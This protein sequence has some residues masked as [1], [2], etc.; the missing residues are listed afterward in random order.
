MGIMF[1]LFIFWFTV[2]FCN[3]CYKIR[4]CLGIAG[5]I[6]NL[7]M[8]SLLILEIF[9]IKRRKII[10]G[11]IIIICIYFIFSIISLIIHILLII[12]K[13]KYFSYKII[14][15]L[16][17]ILLFTD[18]ISS[19][20]N[21]VHFLIVMEEENNNKNVI[22]YV[23][24]IFDIIFGYFIGIHFYFVVMLYYFLS[25]LIKEARK[26]KTP[27]PIDSSINLNMDKKFYFNEEN[28]IKEEIFFSEEKTVEKLLSK[29]I[30]KYKPKVCQN[31]L[32]FFFKDKRIDIQEK[33]TIKNYFELLDY[34]QEIT[35][36]VKVKDKIN[37][38]IFKFDG[39]YE[40]KKEVTLCIY[41][42]VEKLISE[43]LKKI[44]LKIDKKNM[45]FFLITKKLISMDKLLFKN[46]LI[47][48]KK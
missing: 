25:Q 34:N 20:I 42:T 44:E 46:I 33:S 41:E 36:D 6:S 28:N 4:H 37:I 13:K 30:K 12:F 19:I 24:W 22:S 27:I 45:Y 17:G 29:Y 11:D 35:I 16:Y 26:S 47:L 14:K 5:L 9:I 40:L 8:I 31:D 32:Y 18:A 23:S 38:K 7:I 10:N 15:V 2:W 3:C 21:F 48:I 43:Y 1:S 39:I